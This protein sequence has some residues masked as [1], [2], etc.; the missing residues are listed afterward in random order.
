[1]EKEEE[2]EIKEEKKE[3]ADEKID[4]QIEKD[5]EYYDRFNFDW[6]EDTE[7]KSLVN[8]NK[9]YAVFLLLLNK[10]INLQLLNLFSL[11]SSLKTR[12][13]ELR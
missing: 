5:I 7:Y 10:I 13:A 1:M 3:E 12:R 2:E 6:T 4:E 9:I 11:G 8:H